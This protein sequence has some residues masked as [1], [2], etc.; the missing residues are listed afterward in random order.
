MDKQTILTQNWTKTRKIQELILLGLT[1]S[2]IA[3]LVTNG[4]YGFVQNV[5]A[6]MKAEGRLNQVAVENFMPRP[7]ERRFGIEIEMYG[8]DKQVLADTL[9]DAGINCF[10]EGYNHDT[11]GWWKVVTDGSL[12]GVNAVELVSPILEGMAG[13]QD[14]ERVCEVF[15]ILRAKIN[16][17]C[18]LHVHFDAAGMGLAEIK[19]LMLNYAAYE[20]QID[21]FMPM[22]RRDNNNTYC[23]SLKT[24]KS[25][26]ENAM[27]IL[28]LKAAI[29]TRYKKINLE[30]IVRHGSVEFRQHSGTTEFEK[31]KNWVLFLHNL[32]DYS[33]TKRV[34][35]SE[36]TFESIQKFNQEEIYNYL[37]NRK[38][39]L[40]A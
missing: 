26:I 37:Y 30:S 32:V 6:K 10:V 28:G 8:V 40:A 23:K 15:T 2:E 29:G 5:Y 39:D 20:G 12:N 17:S 25:K 9:R 31:I 19:N 3:I 21:S 7:F 24:E 27:S 13:M 1:R 35:E 16:K 18:G 14:L 11:R 36:A 33:K 38:N 22:S 34:A 4:N